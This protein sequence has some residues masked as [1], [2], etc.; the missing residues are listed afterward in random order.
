[1]HIAAPPPIPHQRALPD[2]LLHGSD[3][4]L[5]PNIWP[6]QTGPVVLKVRG[7]E[8][9]PGIRKCFPR[10]RESSGGVE[11]FLG[12]PSPAGRSNAVRRAGPNS[13]TARR[14]TKASSW[15]LSLSHFGDSLTSLALN[16]DLSGPWGF[17]EDRELLPHRLEGLFWPWLAVLKACVFSKGRGQW[18]LVGTALWS[19][20]VVSERTLTSYPTDL[21]TPSHFSRSFSF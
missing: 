12:T 13:A 14:I 19:P 5:R 15:M 10:Q 2:F 11:S 17:V 21:R 3:P 20:C 16:P 7:E 18:W 4:S 6:H 8:N 9:R 1:M